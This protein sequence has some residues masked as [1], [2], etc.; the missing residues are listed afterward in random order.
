MLGR[1]ITGVLLTATLIYA[2]TRT[3]PAFGGRPSRAER[4]AYQ[5][6][7]ASYNGRRFSYPP[8]WAEEGMPEDVRVSE[9][10]TRPRQPL[11]VAK[12]D[13]IA[14]EKAKGAAVTWLGHSSLLVQ[15]Q[16]KNLLIDPV[17]SRRTSPVAFGGPRP[18][19]RPLSKRLRRLDSL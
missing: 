4:A 17:F 9:K 16:G 7:V 11:P 8:E 13:F 3:W 5:R 1:I 14:G 2:F 18:I 19:S 15:M 6:S 10:A 12:P